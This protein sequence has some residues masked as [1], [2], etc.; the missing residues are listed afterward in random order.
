RHLFR[1]DSPN[2]THFLN[3]LRIGD[4][5]IA[6]EKVGFLAV[7]P[8]AL[9]V[10]LTGEGGNACFRTSDLAGNQAHIRVARN[11]VC[12]LDLLFD[13]ASEQ[14]NR[15]RSLAIYLSGTDQLLRCDTGNFASVFWREGFYCFYQFFVAAC[16]V[17]DKRLIDVSILNK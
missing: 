15:V 16:V 4:L 14:D 2:L 3:M 1:C 11:V 7:L 8:P 13:S 17:L 10:A 5:A 6:W 9:T 12:S